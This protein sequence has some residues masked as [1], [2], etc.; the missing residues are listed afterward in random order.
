MLTVNFHHPRLPKAT[1]TN[2]ENCRTLAWCSYRRIWKNIVKCEHRIWPVKRWMGKAQ[3]LITTERDNKSVRSRN[4]ISFSVGLMKSLRGND[5]IF[6][7]F[8]WNPRTSPRMKSNP[9]KYNPAKQDFIANAI[10]STGGGFHPSKTDLTAYS[11]LRI[12]RLAP[13]G[14]FFCAHFHNSFWTSIRSNV[15]YHFTVFV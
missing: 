14:F 1:R 5:E 6:T 12:T 9:S 7:S 2:K 10:S 11:P 15:R 8:R 3:T 4:V 13:R